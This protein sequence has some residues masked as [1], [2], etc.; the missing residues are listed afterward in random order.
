MIVQTTDQMQLIE[1]MQLSAQSTVAVESTD[2]IS[3]E[4]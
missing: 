2:C 3:T 1:T 4:G